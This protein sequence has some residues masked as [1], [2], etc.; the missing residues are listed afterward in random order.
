MVD[1]SF[2][3]QLQECPYALQMLR[4][5][6]RSL[7]ATKSGLLFG[8]I[9]HKV[10]ELR[11]K[12]LGSALPNPA[13]EAEQ[14]KLIESLYSSNPFPEDDWRTANWAVELFVKRYNAHYQIEPFN[15]LFDKDHKP[16][17]EVPFCV[18]L[19]THKMSDGRVIEV[20]HIGRI[21]LV[22][23]ERGSTYIVDHKCLSMLGLNAIDDAKSS[24]QFPGYMRGFRAATGILPIGFV[25]NFIRTKE[26]PTKPKGGLDAWWDEN[27]HR[28]TEFVSEQ[29]LSEWE[30]NACEQV[31]EF[32]WR[33]ENDRFTQHKKSCVVKYGKCQYYGIC[34]ESPRSQHAELL[35]SS[36]YEDY[37]WSPLEHN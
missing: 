7:A 9:G 19:M 3:S 5:Q 35:S 1:N 6:R 21:D 31:E 16:L 36:M 22:V 13:F 28:H 33:Y 29:Q 4:I 27:Y 34:N 2:L 23:E 30:Q 15:I 10:L 14:I 12:A 20:D 18:P 32:F 17:V 25:V 37:N 26:A 24:P 11:Y 8:G